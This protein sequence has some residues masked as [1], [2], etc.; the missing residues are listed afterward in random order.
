MK[1]KQIQGFKDTL[2][3]HDFMGEI[4]SRVLEAREVVANQQVISAPAVKSTLK[5]G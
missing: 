4:E 1:L 2:A 3:A 5:L